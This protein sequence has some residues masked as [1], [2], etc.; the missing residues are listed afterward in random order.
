MSGIVAVIPARGGSKGIPRKNLVDLGG[1]PLIQWTIEAAIESRALD[2]VIVSTED[3]EIA[4]CARSAGAEVPFL[5]PPEL[6]EDSVHAVH[7]VLHALDWLTHARQAAP[8]GVMMLLPTAPLR[9]PDDIRGAV[10]LFDQHHANSVISVV[11]L[12]KYLT[13]LRFMD[14]NQLIVTAPSESRNAQRQGLRKLY[15]VNGSIFLAKPEVLY[16]AGTFHVPSAL[17]YVMHPLNSVDINSYEDLELA[18]LLCQKLD[19]WKQRRGIVQ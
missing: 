14:G 10:N 9:L 5:R 13:N 6:A 16:A 11:D 1:K 15:S 8:D 18:R 19:P 7:V 2:R 4:A 17:G 12:G 3:V